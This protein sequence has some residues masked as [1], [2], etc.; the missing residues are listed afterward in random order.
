[1]INCMGRRTYTAK[2]QG[3]LSPYQSSGFCYHLGLRKVSE[4]W[5]RCYD[6]HAWRP[7]REWQLEQIPDDPD[8]LL[9]GALANKKIA[10]FEA[11]TEQRRAEKTLSHFGTVAS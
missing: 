10:E 7:N 1:M 5:G 6:C 11:R 9:V 8:P 3:R 4:K 2:K